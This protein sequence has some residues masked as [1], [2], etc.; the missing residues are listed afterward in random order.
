MALRHLRLEHAEGSTT[1]RRDIELVMSTHTFSSVLVL[2]TEGD[3]HVTSDS[4]ALTSL[5]L[6]RDIRQAMRT[7]AAPPPSLTLST[8][9]STL[10]AA[11][12]AAAA[13]AAP[14]A[15]PLPADFTLLGEILDS[16]TKDLVA[17]A[18]I[19]DYIMSNR[20][21]AKVIA[22]V[23]EVA[24]VAPILDILFAE[25]GDEICVRDVR[26]YALPTEAL[27]F[28]SMGARARARR[29]VAIG[30]KRRGGGVVLNPEGKHE[31]MTWDE[32]DFLIVIGE[33]SDH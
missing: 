4:R 21:M 27:S 9:L 28:F 6:V 10:H 23:S 16:E 20:L 7:R 22:M 5:L 11:L 17:M 8:T 29:E 19:S 13:A 3:R 1:H 32:G 18:G 25:E 24:S 2:A 14:S 30:Y 15:L 26:R 12:P 31:R 33:M